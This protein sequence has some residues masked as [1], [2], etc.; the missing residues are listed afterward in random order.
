MTD[1]FINITVT[2]EVMHSFLPQY[3]KA[4]VYYC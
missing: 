4:A 1:G 2:N 3:W